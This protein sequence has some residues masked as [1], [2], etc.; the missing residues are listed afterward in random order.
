MPFIS[1]AGRIFRIQPP[2]M[3]FRQTLLTLFALALMPAAQ[4]QC[5]YTL[6]MFEML[7]EAQTATATAA[8]NGELSSV[9][10]DLNFSGTGASY[11]A[12]RWFTSGAQR[13]V[14]GLGRWN[15]P[16]TALARH[17]NWSAILGPATGAPL[18]GFYTYTL[19]TADYNLFGTGTWSVT[20]QNAWTAPVPTIWTLFSTDLAKENAPMR[21][22]ATTWRNPYCPTTTLAFT[23]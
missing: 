5:T 3:S 14:R 22:L 12:E 19:N 2:T 7:G 15:I 10:F 20:I 4:A 16:P 1:W 17:R 8:L 9:T 11:P 23:P 21:R 6:S 13:R 18:N